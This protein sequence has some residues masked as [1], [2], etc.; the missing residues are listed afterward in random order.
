M[1]RSPFNCAVVC[2]AGYPNYPSGKEHGGE[3]YVPKNKSVESN[4][5]LYAVDDATVYIS[6]KQTG[7][8]K[9]GYGAY[10]NYLVLQCSNGLW[11]L[12]AH[13]KEK[14]VVQAGSTVKK[15]QLVGITGSTGNST[16]RHLHIE[17]SDMRGV[18]YN[19][20]NWYQ[21][22]VAHR[23]KPSDYIDFSVKDNNAPTSNKEEV[24]V[25]MKTW[26]NG[27][28]VEKVYATDTD[29]ASNGKFGAPIRILPARH[30]AECYAVRVVGGVKVYAIEY[31]VPNTGARENGYVLWHG[32]VK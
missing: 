15:G 13:L 11:V 1:Y 31:F 9:G 20:S 12:Y 4:W 29:A 5:N 8:Y 28:T 16:G 3:D 18:K 6:K 24:F 23:V 17:V 10:G 21:Q 32:G 25:D 2:T 22:F 26:K 7:T 27:S 30:T 14:P 19:G